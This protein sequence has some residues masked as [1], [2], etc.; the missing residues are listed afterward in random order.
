[1]SL[2]FNAVMVILVAEVIQNSK[3]WLRSFKALTNP[4][5]L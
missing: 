1:M 5:Y 3:A 2:F 4:L